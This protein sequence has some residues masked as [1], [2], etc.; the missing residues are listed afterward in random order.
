MPDTSLGTESEFEVLLKFIKENRGFDF[1]GY[2]RPSLHRRIEKRMQDAGVPTY[3]E[4]LKR[5]KSDEEEFA[6][7]F[8][9]ILI[10]VTGFFR[11]PP[12]WEYLRKELVPKIVA[13][14]GG[15]DQIRIWSAGCATGEEAYSLAMIFADELGDDN[16]AD[17]VK[18]YATDIDERAL[19]EGRHGIFA[20]DQVKDVPPEHRERYFESADSRFVFSM[21]LRRAVIFGR[22]DLLVDPP[23][24]RIDLISCRNTLMYFNP[25]VQRRILLNFHF[26]LLPTGY[27]FLGRSETLLTRS[28]LFVALDLK[29]RVFS[30]G[31]REDMQEQLREMIEGERPPIV[32]LPEAERIRQASFEAA[33]IAQLVVDPAGH[34]AAANM[35]ARALFSLSQRDLGRPLQDL[36]L[37]YRPVELRSVIEQAYAAHHTVSLR[38]VEWVRGSDARSYDIQVG[39]LHAHDGS[40][41]GMS[42]TF[43]ETTRYRKLQEANELQKERLETAYEELQSTAEELET[44][45]EELQSTNEELETTNEELQSTNEEL[46]TM[47]EE[48]QSTNEELNTMNDELRLRTED[49]HAVNSFLESILGGLHAGVAVTDRELRIQ[50][51]NERARDLWGLH[52]SE[53]HGQHLMNLDIGLPVDQVM[54][55]LRGVLNDGSQDG[56]ITLEATNRRGRPILCRVRVSPM[57]GPEGGV[58]GAILVMDEVESKQAE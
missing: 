28:N 14:K 6:Q 24:S 54:P 13:A 20:A 53:V 36:E 16:F 11:D 2:K 26:A 23:I 31:V 48:L 47:N 12:A 41:V 55:L 56:E 7:L 34:L 1:S 19:S 50:A 9:T 22:N 5:L 3:A 25:D 21:D 29:K 27:L 49:L 42:I 57:N 10:N 44:T 18:I 45:N 30:R 32:A 4:Y 39:P 33:P 17:R 37:S 40:L 58:S 51:W 15:D 46:E 35:Q 43:A 52:A 8:D 38:D